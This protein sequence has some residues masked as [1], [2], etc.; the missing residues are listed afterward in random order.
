MFGFLFGGPSKAF[1]NLMA[2][3]PD[4]PLGK[5]FE[6][7]EAPSSDLTLLSSS[8]RADLLEEKVANERYYALGKIQTAKG[9]ILLFYIH[10]GTGPYGFRRYYS[11]RS[12]DS[13][14]E[15]QFSMFLCQNDVEASGFKVEPSGE[16]YRIKTHSGLGEYHRTETTK[17]NVE[18][19]RYF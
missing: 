8:D 1:K 9:G 10:E 6:A 5:V 7:E 3:F 11:L 17:L 12:Y 19:K 15:S 14:G 13:K 4:F 16:E 18:G 2:K